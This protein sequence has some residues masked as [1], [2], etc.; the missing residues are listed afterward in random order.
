MTYSPNLSVRLL[1]LKSALVHP[2]V[3]FVNIL[4]ASTLWVTPG[5]VGLRKVI[6]EG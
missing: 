3:P 4:G 2:K 6:S 5:G 1:F